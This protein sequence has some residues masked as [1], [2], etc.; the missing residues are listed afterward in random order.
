MS[1][2]LILLIIALVC[3][4]AALFEVPAWINLTAFAVVF[5]VVALLVRGLA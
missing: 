5:A 3:A 2:S 4:C 1:I